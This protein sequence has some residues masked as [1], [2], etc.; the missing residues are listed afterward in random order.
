[1]ADTF[2]C[3]LNLAA[4]GE[5]DPVVDVV[6]VFVNLTISSD[7]FLNFNEFKLIVVS[8][9]VGCRDC[10]LAIVVVA[11]GGKKQNDQVVL[12]WVLCG[13]IVHFSKLLFKLSPGRVNQILWRH[14]IDS[15]HLHVL[16]HRV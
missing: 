8:V 13:C 9:V 7:V 4:A 11:M 5:L 15:Q 6:Q 2:N 1:M 12:V 3:G 10:L 16:L 14:A